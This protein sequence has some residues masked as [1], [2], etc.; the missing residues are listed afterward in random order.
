MTNARAL[1][2][3]AHAPEIPKLIAQIN[4]YLRSTDLEIGLQHLVL[5]RVSQIN[6]CAYCVDLHSHEALRDGE[7]V[8]RVNCLPVWR[9]CDF[10][11][12]KEKAAFGWA[13][14]LTERRSEDELGESYALVSEFFDAKN[15][16]DL[17]FLIASMNAWNR[18]GVGLGR[19]P[20]ARLE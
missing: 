8:Q 3:W 6:K 13:E 17:T 11:S 1:E 20:E 15:L 4:R 16:S 14:A 7:L 9:E 12:D 2:Y 18:M 10:Y 5:L 19:S